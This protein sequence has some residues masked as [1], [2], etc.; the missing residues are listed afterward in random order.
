[1]NYV[2]YE[3]GC[4]FAGPVLQ[5]E[6]PAECCVHHKKPT[7]RFNVDKYSSKELKLIVALL[8]KIDEIERR[9]LKCEEHGLW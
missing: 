4:H 5:G 9:L 7:A 3:C 8:T 2:V 6:L 1:M